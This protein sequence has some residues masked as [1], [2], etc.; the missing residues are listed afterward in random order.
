[1]EKKPFANF[2]NINQA[3]RNHPAPPPVYFL[4]I[5]FTNLS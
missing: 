1:M 5:S 3:F 4:L 2:Y